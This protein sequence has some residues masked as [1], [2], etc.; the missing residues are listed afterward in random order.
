MLFIGRGGTKR[1]TNS[2][3]DRRIL[4]DRA[5]RVRSFVAL[6]N[7]GIETDASSRSVA[8]PTIA[9]ALLPKRPRMIVTG[10]TNVVRRVGSVANDLP[11]MSPPPQL[12]R[13]HRLPYGN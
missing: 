12:Q 6:E 4:P 3:I 10:N 2:S 11:P 13:Q 1:N 7:G 8:K 9:V 5:S